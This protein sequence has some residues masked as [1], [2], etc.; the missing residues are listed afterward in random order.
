M[1]G[2]G[3]RT[4]PDLTHDTADHLAEDHKST[5]LA[6]DDSHPYSNPHDTY[7]SGAT[8]GAGFGN[9]TLL[10]TL[11]NSFTNLVFLLPG[12]KSAP[13]P[14][15]LDNSEFRF[16]SHKNTD[17]YSGGTR[18]GSGSTAGAGFGNKTGAFEASNGT[19]TYT[20]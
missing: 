14:D 18:H 13:D 17:V 19:S 7:G 16:G 10:P 20:F 1:A 5:R 11:A 8:G 6:R 15:Q 3:N 4:A 2:F 9:N 12:N